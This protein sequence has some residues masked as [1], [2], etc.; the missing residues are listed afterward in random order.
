MPSIASETERMFRMK[1]DISLIVKT[2]AFGDALLC[3][4]AVSELIDSGGRWQVL[5][6]PAAAPV[7]ER[8]HGIERIFTAPFPP[9][10]TLGNIK[11]LIWSIKN[12]KNF[13]HVKQ[14][15]V[16]QASPAVRRWVRFLTGSA[17]RSIGERSLGRWDSVF[18]IVSDAFIGD[19]YAMLGGVTPKSCKPLFEIHAKDTDW[20][21]RL[22][23][24][25]P[26]VVFA[27]G[28]GI[29]PRDTVL[30]KRWSVD[31]YAEILRR[32]V[33]EGF[34]IV[35]LG[36]AG[37]VAISDE[38]EQS[39]GVRVL[40]LTGKTTWGQSAAILS[41]CRC[42]AGNDSGT[43]HLAVSVGKP[44]LVVFGPTAPEFL[45]SPGSILPVVPEIACS[46]CYS[47][48][49]FPGCTQPSLKCMEA[50][51]IDRTWNILRGVINE[52]NSS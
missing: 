16:F 14:A 19:S 15:Y 48:M 31:R 13:R 18:P 20:G 25:T 37:D 10:D 11:L 42:F 39:A 46:P 4:P 41:R 3:T 8:M 36:G 28:G 21:E 27:I 45:Y 43:A 12:R 52:D 5:T 7:W 6:G 22:G 23:I 1:S 17:V 38:L 51:D 50:I 33:L 35:L 24:K 26:Y 9:K 34:N 40:N 44:A 49:V 2:H 30:E 47:N 29:N 32:T